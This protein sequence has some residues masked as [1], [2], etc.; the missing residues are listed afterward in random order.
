MRFFTS[1][2]HLGHQNIIG[3]CDRPYNTVH[4]M[5]ED[6]VAR[7]NSRVHPQDEVWILGDLCMGKLDL[8]LEFVQRMNG[9]KYLVPG[10]HDRMFG[11]EGT[12]YRHSCLRYE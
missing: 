11:T 10:N 8:S 4:E 5:N 9:I 2:L 1:D 6:L 7:F 3:F 12:K